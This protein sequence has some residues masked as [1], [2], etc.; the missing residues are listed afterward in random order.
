M[1]HT[2]R[3]GFIPDLLTV[4]ASSGSGEFRRNFK[5]TESDFTDTK[6]FPYLFARAHDEL[7]IVYGP[8]LRE[9]KN[10]TLRCFCSTRPRLLA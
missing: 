9:Q 6:T 1:G 5:F 4:R 3:C 2:K 8:R 10:T 7:T